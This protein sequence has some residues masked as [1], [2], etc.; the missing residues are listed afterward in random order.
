MS[1]GQICGDCDSSG[2]SGEYDGSILF[3]DKCQEESEAQDATHDW[4]VVLNQLTL[5]K[6][7][8]GG[9]F[10]PSK[11]RPDEIGALVLLGV[12]LFSDVDDH[13]VSLTLCDCLCFIMD[14]GID[15]C[16]SYVSEATTLRL[17][18]ESGVSRGPG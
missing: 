6:A 16:P 17:A 9:E 4:V 14:K 12:G 7:E 11:Y 10:Q 3:C 2:A 5:G 13:E 1:D 8:S 15:H 18:I